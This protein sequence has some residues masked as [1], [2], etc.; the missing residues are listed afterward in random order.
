LKA[1]VKFDDCEKHR[2]R[3]NE[4][5]IYSTR[6]FNKYNKCVRNKLKNQI[7][8]KKYKLCRHN[9]GIEIPYWTHEAATEGCAGIDATKFSRV[10][11]RRGK[12]FFV[13]C[14]L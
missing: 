7:N 2:K 10:R 1:A 12:T 9:H 8:K 13:R 3:R 11:N 6:A 5:T 4:S 14:F